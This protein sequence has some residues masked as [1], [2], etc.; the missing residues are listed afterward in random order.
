MNR[1]SGIL[2]HIVVFYPI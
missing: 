1:L 2:M